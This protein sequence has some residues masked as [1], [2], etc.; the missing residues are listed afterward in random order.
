MQSKHRLLGLAL[1]CSLAGLQPSYAQVRTD[2]FEHQRIE[3]VQVTIDNPSPDAALN[4]RVEDL[5][6]RT[7]AAYPSSRFSEDRLIAALA[8]LSRAPEIRA[9]RHEVVNGSTGGV[10]LRVAVTLANGAAPPADASPQFPT[11]Y[12]SNGTLVR[13]KLETLA[14]YY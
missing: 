6:R 2:P 9:T 8:R 1:F 10:Q 3:S 7:L 12:Q 4:S 5:V 13:A 14:M 11:L